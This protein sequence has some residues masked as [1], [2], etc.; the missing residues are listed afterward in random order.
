MKREL[1][2]ERLRRIVMRAQ[3][4][5]ELA[6]RGYASEAALEQAVTELRVEVLQFTADR[7]QG[8]A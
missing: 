1:Q 5:L 3:K 4:A 8:R 6:K 7:R 2:A